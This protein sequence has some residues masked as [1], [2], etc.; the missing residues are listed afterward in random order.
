MQ[1]REPKPLE[2]AP[3]RQ[4]FTPSLKRDLNRPRPQDKDKGKDEEE[5]PEQVKV[6]LTQ[7]RRM[8]LVTGQLPPRLLPKNETSAARRAK[9]KN[10]RRRSRSKSKH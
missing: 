8:N 10:K 5:D 1:L 9:P 6:P 7:G 2:K 3:F 4:G